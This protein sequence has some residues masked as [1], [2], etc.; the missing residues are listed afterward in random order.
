MAPFQRARAG[1]S[2]TRVLTLEDDSY[3]ARYDRSI[4]D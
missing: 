4:C 2:K 1:A 3:I